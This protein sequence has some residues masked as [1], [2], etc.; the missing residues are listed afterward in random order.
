MNALI[1]WLRFSSCEKSPSL[2]I[3]NGAV[4]SLKW[5]ALVAMTSDHVNKII[6][7]SQLPLMSEFGRIAMPLFGMVL[8]YNLARPEA[9]QKGIHVPC[10]NCEP[11]GW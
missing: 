5:L 11:F 1:G 2:V 8:A 4:E 7:K 6:F 9:L 10:A 3:S